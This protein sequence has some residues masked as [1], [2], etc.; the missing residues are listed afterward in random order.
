MGNSSLAEIT[1]RPSKRQAPVAACRVLYDGQCE[2][3]Q[4]CV[5]WL[6]ALDHENKT[7]MPAHQRRGLA[8]SGL[9]APGG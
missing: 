4:A 6:K 8:H 7:V 2:I 1:A 9:P 5:S 3:C